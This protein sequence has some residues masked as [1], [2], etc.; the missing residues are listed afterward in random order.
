MNESEN[1]INSTNMKGIFDRFNKTFDFSSKRALWGVDQV[2]N[3]LLFQLQ[4]IRFFSARQFYPT[5][6]LRKAFVRCPMET[7]FGRN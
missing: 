1:G 3:F 4:M 7:L 6:S 2:T 5:I